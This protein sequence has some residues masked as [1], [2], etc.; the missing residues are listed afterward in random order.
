[1]IIQRITLVF[2]L[3]LG[4]MP[5]VQALPYIFDL[6]VGKAH[7]FSLDG[8]QYTIELLDVLYQYGPNLWFGK[9]WRQR[10]LEQARVHIKV[11]GKD[12]VLLQRPYQLPIE[13]EGLKLYVENT[14]R[15]AREAEIQQI[16]DLQADVRLSVCPAN[17]SWGPEAL[18]FPIADYRWRST[19]YGNTWSALVPFNKLYYHR[20][21][22]FGAIPDRLNVVAILDGEVIETPLPDG[23]GASNGLIIRH[24][25]GLTYR[26]GH[27]NIESINP[28]LTV[29][30][31]VKAGD[32]V[33]KTGST[34]NGARNQHNDP[35]L[36]VGFEYEGKK[37]ST[38][39]F[40]AEAY[41]RDYPDQVLAFS[42]GY[43]FT[44]VGEE[45]LLDAS[46]SLAR[47]GQ[48]INKYQWKLSNGKKVKGDTAKITYKQPGM[49]TEEL[50][51]RTEK[52]GEDRDYIQ[53][54]V[55]EKGRGNHIAYGWV[56]HTPL[57]NIHAGKEVL[58][59]NR[60]LKTTAPVMIDFGDNS[61]PK[62][63]DKEATHIYGKA[64]IYTVTYTS[65]GPENEAVSAKMKVVVEK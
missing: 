49:Y 14:F 18:K 44:L 8:K 36:H 61:P 46:R 33:G 32:I 63:I 56:Y 47:P 9:M 57:R 38:F 21:D 15:W 62:V 28:G 40:L 27:M 30:T 34:W 11:N 29:G 20:G 19:P 25:S 16:D 31:E 65:K 1:M 12:V 54:R 50:I 53:V 26:F 41:F 55:Y 51:V 24:P 23:D 2:L 59:W 45:V 13:F 39:P 10:T 48:Q 4:G 3:F 58:F 42:G 37:I 52:G 22:D 17:D 60:L 7:E 43:K 6:D 5:T 64:G 35:H